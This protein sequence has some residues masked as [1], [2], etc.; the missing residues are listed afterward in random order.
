MADCPYNGVT[1]L[2]LK[3]RTPA[4]APDQILKKEKTTHEALDSGA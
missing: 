3:L 4:A 2:R 1:I